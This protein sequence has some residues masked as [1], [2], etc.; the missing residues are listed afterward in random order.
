MPHPRT[1]AAVALSLVM[2]ACAG[3]PGSPSDGGGNDGGATDGGGGT[4]NAC[5][6]T[7]V[8][9]ALPPCNP[10]SN[11][12]PVVV[13]KGCTP[14]VD[15]TLHAEEWADATC[16]NVMSAGS[17]LMPV[18]VKYGQDAV[19]VAESGSQ[20]GGGF[21]TY[22]DPDDS[23]AMG[24]EIDV[25]VFDDAFGTD[26]DRS[27][28]AYQNG[29]WSTVATPVSGVIVKNPANMNGAPGALFTFEWKIPFSAVGIAPGQAHAFR[30]GID[31]Q[32]AA[33]PSS[34]SPVGM[35][36]DPS[37]WGRLTSTSWQ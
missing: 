34:A 29:A 3:G 26:G 10:T 5:A 16:F 22:L 33:W 6:E 14:N 28:G 20:T 17:A 7:T 8:I 19:Y 27:D 18:Y 25:S 37:T 31:Y 23:D 15:G 30:I 9:T 11:D 2:A 32:F 24:D 4:P 36:T 21:I 1:L 12:P 35:G 13:P